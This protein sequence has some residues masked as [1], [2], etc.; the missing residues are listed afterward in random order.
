[1]P[2]TVKNY[3]TLNAGTIPILNVIRQNASYQYQNRIPL[4][5][6]E[7]DI[8]KVGEMVMGD[9]AIR[10][11]FINVLNRIALVAVKSVLFNNPFKH[12]KKG[13]LEFGETVEEIFV[14]MGKAQKLSPEK[15]Y[16][17]E[18]KRYVPDVKSTFH[19]INWEVQYPVSI[20][21]KDLQ[22]AFLSVSGMTDF[23]NRLVSSIY[24]AAEYDEYL[25]FKYVIIKHVSHG[26]SH[27]VY[28][29]DNEEETAITLRSFAN[30]F[31]F[32]S[33]KYNT[34]NVRNS[35]APEYTSV[36]MDAD[37]NARYDVKVL[38]AMFNMD[39]AEFSGKLEIVDD[40]T[41]FDND[42]FSEILVDSNSIEPVT[43]EE[44]EAMKNVKAFVCSDGFFQFYD[45]WIRMLETQVSSGAYINYFLN[46]CKIVSTS[47]Y[48]NNVTVVAGTQEAPPNTITLNVIGVKKQ[49][50]TT[51]V[52]LDSVDT[53]GL[54][55]S[56]I[57]YYTNLE[58][59]EA[60]VGV[61]EYGAYLFGKDNVSEVTPEI[62]LND[63]HYI[64]GTKLNPATVQV[65]DSFTC[66]KQVGSKSA[67]SN[68]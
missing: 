60:E 21:L 8:V 65:G 52:E 50:G 53:I 68:Q 64:A 9:A 66:T 5:T 40:F 29:A 6:K 49:N 22:R 11:E 12:L 58:S 18:F 61:T 25:L 46:I 41:S 63:V 56:N 23:I 36:F 1:M 48:E 42:R 19:V 31:R 39:K 4:L 15:A 37:Y 34:A 51:V 32:P 45:N 24:K 26:K 20:S 55:Y 17:R 59:V 7:N 62:V 27:V 28:I 3:S 44:L 30:K 47:P 2:S 13:Y 57:T 33:K 10:N 54:Q 43:T 67:K 16:S 38:A 14:E 35:V